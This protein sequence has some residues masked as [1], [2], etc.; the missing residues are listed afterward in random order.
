VEGYMRGPSH[1]LPS[2]PK[3]TLT[4][5][6]SNIQGLLFFAYGIVCL[7]ILVPFTMELLCC[8]YD[9]ILW[10]I[11]TVTDLCLQ[12]QMKEVTRKLQF[13]QC[14]GVG[15]LSGGDGTTSVSKQRG[16]PQRRKV[17]PIR[18]K[19]YVVLRPLCNPRKLTQA[20]S[21]GMSQTQR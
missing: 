2:H 17:F 8:S 9:A 5:F 14:L 3:D 18:A 13:N 20:C 11:T 21:P 4:T 12:K 1:C 15:D 10:K 19:V 6:R 7:P 16:A